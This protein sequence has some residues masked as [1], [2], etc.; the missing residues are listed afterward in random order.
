M[1]KSPSLNIHHFVFWQLFINTNELSSSKHFSNINLSW[2]DLQRQIKGNEEHIE[3]Q[4]HKNPS[5]TVQGWRKKKKN[6]PSICC[7]SINKVS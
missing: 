2:T 1:L 3:V 7:G 5:L 6:G 4:A